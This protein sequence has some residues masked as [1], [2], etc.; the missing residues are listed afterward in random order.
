MCE[1]SVLI[2]KEGGRELLMEE[3]V[4]VEVDGDDIKL[5]GILGEIQHAKGRIRE[6]NLMKHTIVIEIR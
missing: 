1:S 3:V 5:R 6:T 4:H 2:E